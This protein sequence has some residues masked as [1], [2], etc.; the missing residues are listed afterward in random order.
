[1]SNSSIKKKEKLHRNKFIPNI[2]THK[3]KKYI[4]TQN[5]WI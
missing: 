4:D 1:M 2:D 3:L 5:N